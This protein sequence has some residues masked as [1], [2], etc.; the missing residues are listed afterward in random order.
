MT[1]RYDV[2]DFEHLRLTINSI[3]NDPKQLKREE[4]FAHFPFFDTIGVLGGWVPSRMVVNVVLIICSLV[5]QSYLVL[6]ESCLFVSLFA[7]Y[8]TESVRRAALMSRDIARVFRAEP[9]E[10]STKLAEIIRS[11]ENYF[12][13]APTPSSRIGKHFKHVRLMN[14]VERITGNLPVELYFVGVVSFLSFRVIPMVSLVYLG[15]ALIV[16]ALLCL[17]ISGLV[18]MRA[19][20]VRRDIPPIMR[21]EDVEVVIRD[22]DDPAA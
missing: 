21:Q 3:E 12:A 22:E 13:S 6:W 14:G 5:V 9:G 7:T 17:P 19:D 15:L 10:R 20:R 2:G 11:H 16:G 1:I 18:A 8:G 4:R